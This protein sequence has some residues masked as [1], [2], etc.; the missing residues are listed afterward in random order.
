M[1][2][3]NTFLIFLKGL[4]MGICDLI[5]GISGGTIAFITGIYERLIN[6]IKGF[7]LKLLIDFFTC[8]FI[9]K[10]ENLNKLKKDIKQLDLGFLIILFLGIGSALLLG[11]SLIKYLLE[12]YS[13]YTLSFFIGLILASGLLIFK[14]IKNHNFINK[15]FSLLGLIIGISLGFIVPTE[16]YPNLLYIFIGGFVAVSAMFLPGIS[17]AFIL[18]ILG[19]YDFMVNVLHNIS[20]NLKYFLV[21]MLGAILGGL[22]ISRIISFL[23]KKDK[24]KTLYFLLGLVIGALSIPVKRVIGELSSG[25]SK[26]ILTII[27]LIIGLILVSIISK[28][29]KN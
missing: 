9:W 1:N 7:S 8:L 3:K 27:Y 24:C 6:S 4:L 17:G 26:I 2:T 12:N 23:F 14:H 28:Y 16:I 20:G 5:P 13:G 15:L 10:K 19:L 18:L 11:S 25:N 21:F 22:S 29:S